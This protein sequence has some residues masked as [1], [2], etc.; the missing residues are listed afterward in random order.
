MEESCSSIFAVIRRK[1][2][3]TRGRRCLS[4][5]QTPLSSKELSG[6]TSK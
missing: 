6:E 4:K 1:Y 3:P 5:Q 2:L